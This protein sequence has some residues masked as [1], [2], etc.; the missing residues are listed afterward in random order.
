[1]SNYS[2]HFS[3]TGGTKKVADTLTRAVDANVVAAVAQRLEPLLGRHK[4]NHLYLQQKS[5]GSRYGSRPT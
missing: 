3:P 5:G 4:E 2:I 1:M